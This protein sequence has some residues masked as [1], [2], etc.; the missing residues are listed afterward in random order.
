MARSG[1]PKQM[2]STKQAACHMGVGEGC[3]SKTGR[4]MATAV[5]VV[6]CLGPLSLVGL[7]PW[8][9]AVIATHTQFSAVFSQVTANSDPTTNLV[10]TTT[11]LLQQQQH[12][13][14]LEGSQV[15]PGGVATQLSSARFAICVYASFV[16]ALFAYRFGVFRLAEHAA[17]RPG[18]DLVRFRFGF[19]W[20][21]FG[22]VCFFAT[23]TATATATACLA[24]CR[25]YLH[26]TDT[27]G[28]ILFAAQTIA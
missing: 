16:V 25:K 3:E 6:N 11:R 7:P 20:V 22:L 14:G 17:V 1:P 21:R 13:G 12:R 23:A 19:G 28:F 15:R 4:C 26:P 24:A 9:E 27:L 10:K 8:Q 18:F 5:G 2:L